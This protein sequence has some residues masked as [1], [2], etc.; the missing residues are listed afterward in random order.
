MHPP[1][2]Q[3]DDNLRSAVL[4][5]VHTELN[6]KSKRSNNVVVTGLIPSNIASDGDQ[7]SVL[8]SD[9]LKL[10]IQVRSTFRLGQRTPG[11]IQPLLITLESSEEAEAVMSATRELRRSRS[12]MVRDSIYI[13]RHLTSAEREAAFNARELRR[14][15]NK[16]TN[17]ESA[18]SKLG[19]VP[20]TSPGSE[21]NIIPSPAS[22]NDADGNPTTSSSSSS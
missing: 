16:S 2:S 4:T 17:S 21:P 22:T 14:A 8:C 15:K 11:R 1:S 3:L 5:A 6:V 19:A 9:E 12:P 7:F 10:N 20:S 18:P 13:N